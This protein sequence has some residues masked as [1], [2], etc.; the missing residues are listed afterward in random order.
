MQKIIAEVVKLEVLIPCVDKTFEQIKFLQLL[1]RSN[2][3]L[4][5]S[6]MIKTLALQKSVFDCLTN[7]FQ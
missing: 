5:F 7:I 1:K 6:K 4:S 3:A 2:S